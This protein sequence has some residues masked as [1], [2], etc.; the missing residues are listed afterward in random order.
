MKL[1]MEK[2]Y[3]PMPRAEPFPWFAAFVWGIVLWLFE[4][5]QYALQPSL[6]SSMTYLYHD[7]NR[8]TS[9]RDFLLYNR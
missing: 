7:S 5:H 8:W 6:R 3:I 2:G 9:L 4:Y 1:G